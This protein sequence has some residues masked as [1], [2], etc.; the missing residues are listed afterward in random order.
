MSFSVVCSTTH[1]KFRKV[2]ASAV[3]SSE[4][5]RGGSV[6]G[7]GHIVPLPG[8][9]FWG[10]F[11]FEFQTKGM[12]IKLNKTEQLNILFLFFL[13]ANNFNERFSFYNRLDCFEMS[14]A[15]R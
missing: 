6:G 1:R 2:I 3:Y 13:K 12:L 9:S 10:S 4:E 8:N 11:H 5:G 15:T 14:F 7:G